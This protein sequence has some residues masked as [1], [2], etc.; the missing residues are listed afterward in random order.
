MKNC[1][2]LFSL[3]LTIA[4]IVGCAERNDPVYAEEEYAFQLMSQT[5][6]P[7]WA[8]D[9]WITG[10]TAFVAEDEQK[11]TI[12][13]ISAPENPQLID[14][15]LT[16]NKPEAVAYA[17]MT[18]F[19]LTVEDVIRGGIDFYDLDTEQPCYFTPVFD[20]NVNEFGFKELS[21]LRM[22]IYEADLT[23][24]FRILSVFYDS[25]ESL[26]KKTGGPA[27][28][29]D[30]DRG[31][32][33]GLFFDYDVVYV[34]QNQFGLIIAEAEYDA[35]S[36]VITER[37]SIDT[38]GAARDVALNREKTHAVVADYQAGLTIVD[39]TDRSNPSI[40]GSFL[41]KGVDQVFLIESVGDTVYFLDNFNGM[42]A[43]DVSQPVK[44]K[45]VGR[46][47]TPKPRSLF[48][49]PDHTVFIADENLG[50]IILRWRG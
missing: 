28:V 48:I 50:I 49:M 34:A 41:P 9:I 16:E 19:L 40:V 15:V 11:V 45:L 46:Y 4:F 6:T 3:V 35:F 7:G 8:K 27:G 36:I 2:W 20:A 24:G 22:L 17:P 47:D 37:G 32:S 18:G 44:P 43:V 26:W 21:P 10:D 12:W 1:L 30:I 14:T 31:S 23:E 13:D 29:L 39:V 42:F 5:Q 25:T 38:P 33:Q